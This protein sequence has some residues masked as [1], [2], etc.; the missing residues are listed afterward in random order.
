[1]AALDSLI[2]SETPRAFAS[3]A[4]KHNALVDLI[5]SMV[6]ANGVKVTIGEGRILIE[7]NKDTFGKLVQSSYSTYTFTACV[8][9]APKTF[10]IPIVSGPT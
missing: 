7:M 8:S 5:A 6:G 3:H 10:V 1:M 2:I 9:G 4:A